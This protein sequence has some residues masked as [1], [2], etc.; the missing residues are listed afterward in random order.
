MLTLRHCHGHSQEPRWIPHGTGQWRPCLFRLG[1]CAVLAGLAAAAGL[2]RV[3]TAAP[4]PAPLS[5]PEGT[6]NSGTNPVLDALFGDIPAA[7]AK[8]NVQVESPAAWGTVT[9]P[10]T[11]AILQGQVR[12]EIDLAQ[13]QGGMMPPGMGGTIEQLGLG[14]LVN[15]IRPGGQTM[16]VIS[17]GLRSYAEVSLAEVSG[18]AADRAR[19]RATPVG[20]E[21]LNGVVCKKSSFTLADAEGVTQEG[22]VWNAPALRNFPLRLWL[23]Q[24]K[25]I[26]TLDFREV[27]LTAPAAQVFAVPSGFKKH[28][29][30]EAMMQAAAQ[31]LLE[32][33]LGGM[34]GPFGGLGEGGE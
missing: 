15:I 21:T 13:L 10:A 7:T 17:P 12:F 8:A 23:K 6:S 4:S 16:L 22:F 2:E 31:T 18:V 1:G 20:E 33:A 5:S 19:L 26:I 30:I 11:L 9:L 27:K 28:S 24:D 29:S 3:P 25:N 32:R 14:R 34:L